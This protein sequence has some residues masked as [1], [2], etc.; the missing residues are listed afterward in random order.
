MATVKSTLS[1]QDKMSSTL[2]HITK[3]MNATLQTM[4]NID[5][6][7]LGDSFEE[8]TK[9][10]KLAENQLKKFDDTTSTVTKSSNSLLKTLLGF[11]A[12]QKVF[13]LVSNQLGSAV[14]RLDTI[15]N[16]PKVMSNLGIDTEQA[17]ASIQKLSEGLKGIPTTLDSAVMAVQRFTSANSNI[18]YSTNMF[19]AL[20]NALLAGGASTDIQATALEQ[21]S[22]AYAK[23]KPDMMEWRSLL[24]AMP[25]Q[26]NQIAKAMGTTSTKL[27]E[28]LREGKISMDEFM[29]TII[30]LNEK[31]VA[32]FPSLAEQAKNATGGIGT[33]IANMKAAVTRGLTS[34]MTSINTG[35]S[36]AGL[37]SISQTISNFGT[38]IESVLTKAGNVIKGLITILSP[39]FTLIS[40]IYNFFKNNWSMI[41]PIVMG[42]VTAMAIY[43]GILLANSIFTGMVT[44]A[45]T[46]ST[47]ASVAHGAAITKEMIA[48]TGMTKAQ[49]AL[50]AAMWASPVTWIILAIIAII[51]LIYIVIAIINKV[52]GQSISATGVIVGALYSA[53]A[54]IWNLFIALLDI[55]LM[56]INFMYNKWAMFANFF[57]NLFNDP[58]GSIIH[59]FADMA[60]NVLGILEN[61]ASAIDALFGSNLRSAVSSWRDGLSGAADDLAKKMG[62][63]SYEEKYGK[64]NLTSESLGLKRWAYS[65]AWS[66]GYSTGENFENSI[67]DMFGGDNSL[68]D[69]LKGLDGLDKNL[70][71]VTGSDGTGSKAVKTTTSDDLLSDED[72]QLLLDVATRDY[73][74]NYQQVT[75]NV[76]VTFGDI[77]ETADVDGI[78]E[79]VADKIQEIYDSD[80]EM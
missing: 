48:T 59:L 53:A 24:T 12:L 44:L 8:A 80:L 74:L 56:V 7:N 37:G 26:I 61:I 60:D 1:L 54:F 40:N 35:L 49:L 10:I 11:S 69:A 72:I 16:Y 73:K 55:V 41:A 66:K 22:Q 25:A 76:T 23:G 2:S 52:T 42:I 47:I 46:I 71:E 75:P 20:N 39:V 62:N 31:G 21:L 4:K 14:S 45:K 13:G 27:G 30:Q 57:A 65:D 32:G 77:N 3:A 18:G 50:N 58:I 36:N 64:L 28:G 5:S 68:T 15:N 38:T 43:N 79:V 34:V 29:Q 9:Q 67:K 19:L 70:S 78:L 33:S 63:G 51:A 6:Q 17:Q